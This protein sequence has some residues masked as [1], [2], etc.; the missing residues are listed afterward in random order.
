MPAADP[1]AGTAFGGI[2]IG[3]GGK[4]ICYLIQNG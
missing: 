2:P 4:F 1:A 3:N